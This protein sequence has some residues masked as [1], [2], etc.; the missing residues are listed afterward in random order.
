MAWTSAIAG[1]VVLLLYLFV[2]DTWLVPGDDPQ[3]A[4][5]IAPQLAPNDRILVRRGGTPKFG[6]LARCKS[7]DGRWV[8]GRVFGEPGATVQVQNERVSMNGVA[9]GTRHACAP[10]TL[11]HPVSAQPV[12]LACS[13]E[14]SSS[15]WAYSVLRHAEY[16]EG[17]SLA[18]VPF[19]HLYLVSD[20]RALHADS[21]DFGTVEA[22][23]C[24]HIVY[25]LW[26]DSFLDASRRF[27]I[28]W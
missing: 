8:V 27:T 4:V 5:S 13:V 9:V 12:Q 1:A 22:A 10:V 14:E 18:Q 23:T 21:R 25:R 15:S 26:G 7:H 28:L 24:E 19:G 16:P 6:E 2:F 20:N 3:F 11:I 17:D